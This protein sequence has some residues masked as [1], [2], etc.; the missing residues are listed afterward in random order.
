MN[1]RGAIYLTGCLLLVAYLIYADYIFNVLVKTKEEARLINMHLPPDTKNIR[2]SIEVKNTKLKWKN[3]LHISG[4]AFKRNVAE[5][6]REVYL[7]LK[8]KKTI[9]VFDIEKDKISREDVTKHF[10]LNVKEHRHGI[11]LSIPTFIINENSYKIG[12]VIVDGS[13][14]HYSSS[15]KELRNSNGEFS[16]DNVADYKRE[17]KNVSRIEELN[18]EVSTTNIKFYID[19][20]NISG[21]DLNIEGWAFL[22]GLSAE[23]QKTFVLLKK[24]DKVAAFETVM[25]IRPDVT[26]HFKKSGLDLDSSGFRSKISIAKLEKGKY[27]VGLRIDREGVSVVKYSNKFVEIE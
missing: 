19:E 13:G 12:F 16:V 18:S 22:E 5:S 6:D 15:N 24:H 11:E 2:Y 20:A 8:S 7:V 14:L 9:L 17:V 3:G 1:K 21:K 4:W 10:N 23:S 27:Q 26:K 25:R